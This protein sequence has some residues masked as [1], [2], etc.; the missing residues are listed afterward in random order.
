MNLF[1]NAYAQ[2]GL[3]FGDQPTRILDEFLNTHK[4]SGVALDIGCGDGRD[5]IPLLRRGFNV[6]AIDQSTSAIDKLRRRPEIEATSGK[7]S[8]IHCDVQNWQWPISVFDLIVGITLLDH[9]PG[10]NIDDVSAKLL[11]SLKPSGV[12]FLEVHT[13]DDP[14]FT[15]NDIASEFSSAIKHYFAHNEL[16]D[17]FSKHVR[18]LFYNERRELDLDHGEPHYHG[19]ATLIGQVESEKES[20]QE[21]T[22][23]SPI[24]PELTVESIERSVNFYSN[25]LGFSIIAKAPEDG[26]AV[27]AEMSLGDGH[28]MFQEKGEMFEEIPFFRNHVIG[29]TMLLVLRIDDS[30]VVREMWQ[31]LSDKEN[32]VLPVRETD[33]GTVEF[34]I[35]DPDGYVLIF[36]GQ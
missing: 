5:T 28:I 34:G 6:T 33:Y 8:A 16:L 23:S 29:G 30:N 27:W 25:T 24:V 19:F 32:V 2:D 15:Q 18:V 12:V 22:M 35:T 36:S 14:G 3:L 13:I 17:I 20:N 9:L 31:N 4:I 11:K 1:E 7:L 10:E 26:D 21:E